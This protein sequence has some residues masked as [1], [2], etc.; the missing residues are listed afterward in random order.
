[1]LIKLEVTINY[2]CKIHETTN[3][4]RGIIII[5][6][7]KFFNSRY[8][9]FIFNKGILYGHKRGHVVLKRIIKAKKSKIRYKCYIKRFFF[10]S[11]C[12]LKVYFKI[13]YFF[14]EQKKNSNRLDSFLKVKTIVTYFYD[15]MRSFVSLF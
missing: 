13:I 6:F 12:K 4:L 1:M 3:R 7:V 9:W 15:I 5:D 8:I 10:K 14:R 11:K 2:V